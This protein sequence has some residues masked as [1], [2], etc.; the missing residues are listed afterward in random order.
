[1][2]LIYSVV[3]EESGNIFLSRVEIFLIF[4]LSVYNL[5]NDDE[6]NPASNIEAKYLKAMSVL[7]AV[8]SALF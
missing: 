7:C 4:F 5:I 1:M 2:C 8:G 6:V 3:R